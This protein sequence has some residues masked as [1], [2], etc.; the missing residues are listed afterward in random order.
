MSQENCDSFDRYARKEKFD[1][2]SMSKLVS[3]TIRKTSEIKQL[4]EALFPHVQN[5]SR[6]ARP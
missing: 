4:S 3:V 6:F 1:R 2:E 5:C